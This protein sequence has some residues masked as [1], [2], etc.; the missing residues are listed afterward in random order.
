MILRR[1]A[2]VGFPASQHTGAVL[3]RDGAAR[4][5]VEVRFRRLSR[6]QADCRQRRPTAL[7]LWEGTVALPKGATELDR[8][9]DMTSVP[10]IDRAD[11]SAR[12]LF[13][14]VFRASTWATAT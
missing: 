1:Q 4:S 2:Q 11:R 6:R 13:R 8:V 12:S 3:A 7:P 10:V 9:A 5:T 14:D